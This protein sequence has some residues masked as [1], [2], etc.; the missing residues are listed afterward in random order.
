M[1]VG[2]AS[3]GLIFML[4]RVWDLLID[5]MMGY[6]VDTRPSRLGRV[7]HWLLLSL[8]VL[9]LSTYFLFMPVGDEASVIYLVGWLMV[10]MVGFTM[11]Q[12]PT[13]AWVPAIA[14][15]YDERSRV[16]M[17][18]EIINV[19]A[20][21][22]FLILPALVGETL[23]EK[24]W[25]MG[26]VLIILSGVSIAVA[27]TFVPDPQLETKQNERPDF[28]RKA[29]VA[30]IRNGPLLRIL[31]AY[32]CVGVAVSGTA[33]TYLWAARWGF[34]LDS[35]AEL[36]LVFFF[37][38]GMVCMPAWV[39]WSKR[40]EKHMVVK[41]ICIASSASFLMYLPLRSLGE[42]N[43]WWMSLGAVLSG[44]G[45]SAAF[46]LLRSMIGDLVEVER[47]E[48][49]TDRS[50]LYYALL[51]AAFKTGASLAI[52]IP[53]LLLGVLVGFDP[54][55]ENSPATIDGLMYV[56]VLVPFVFYGFA[57]LI[58]RKYPITRDVHAEAT[59]KLAKAKV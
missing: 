20:L 58:I 36:V 24:V 17:W 22:S 12:T 25:V 4:L 16:F 28:S 15:D 32:I 26:L 54:K 19:V 8:P 39:A 45:F 34:K 42:G 55:A 53:Y 37:V 3:T 1:G 59:A 5:P 33:A 13:F 14:P 29:L 57:A 18:F 2:V 7:R 23:P 38:S 21:L 46:T 47:A 44:M 35:G 30:A 11:L 40:A 9:G 56:F 49:G 10:F 50:G 43:F 51:T 48:S 6:L 31:V 52:G 41:W 27:C